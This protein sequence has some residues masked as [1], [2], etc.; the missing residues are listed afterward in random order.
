MSREQ[1]KNLKGITKKNLAGVRF[2]RETGE[3]KEERTSAK[4]G[5]QWMLSCQIFYSGQWQH[6][7]GHVAPITPADKWSNKA[8]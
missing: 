7:C 3:T 8:V 5:R 1:K 4:E 6:K 2:S